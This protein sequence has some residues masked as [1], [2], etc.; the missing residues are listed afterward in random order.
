MGKFVRGASICDV[1]S[2]WG[3]GVPKRQTKGTTSADFCTW[4]GGGVQKSDPKILRTSYKEV[5]SLRL[6]LN[7]SLGMALWFKVTSPTCDTL[8][9]FSLWVS[10]VSH[11]LCS[12]WHRLYATYALILPLISYFIRTE[13]E[14][15]WVILGPFSPPLLPPKLVPF[16][17]SSCCGKN[18]CCYNTTTLTFEDLLHQGDQ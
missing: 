8:H 16:V 4:Q 6:F 2:G 11:N 13:D 9:N 14:I 17:A 3:E 12:L 7:L 5:L 18:P 15:D 10:G 1:R